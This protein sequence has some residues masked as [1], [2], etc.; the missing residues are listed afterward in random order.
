VSEKSNDPAR[1]GRIVAR[2]TA[3]MGEELA[4]IAEVDAAHAFVFFTHLKATGMSKE[5]AM[6]SLSAA[7]D[8]F[9]IKGVTP[10]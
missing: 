1:V 8:K 7:W 9:F 2:I 4:E 10:P 5:V 6:Q 3:A